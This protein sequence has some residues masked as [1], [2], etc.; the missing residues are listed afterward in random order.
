MENLEAKDSWVSRDYELL[1]IKL[2]FVMNYEDL[3][4]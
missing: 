1:L 3:D 2:F 4:R